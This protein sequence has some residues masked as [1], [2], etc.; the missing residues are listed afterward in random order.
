MDDHAVHRR[1]TRRDV[2]R[3]GIGLEDVLALDVDR[4][5]AAIDRGVEH[6]GNA[7]PRLGIERDAPVG[8]EQRAGLAIGDVAVAGKFVREAAHVAGALHVVLAA[9]RVH[10]DAGPAD[11]AG[12]HREVGDG[13]YRRSLWLCSVTPRP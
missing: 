4:A 10:P 13:H 9:Q 12:R 8:L 3:I 5:E 1:Q 11:V 7:Q 2:A 6:V